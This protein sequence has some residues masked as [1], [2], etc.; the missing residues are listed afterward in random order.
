VPLKLT[1]KP[2]EKI[3]I[4]GAV[5]QNGEETTTLNVL[6]EVPL[7]REKDILTEQQA[8]TICKRIYL[9][10]QLMYM[11]RTNLAMYQQNFSSLL[12]EVLNAAPSTTVYL[13]GICSD[14]AC[15]RY[16]QALK[17]ARALVE[18]E[19]GLIEHAKQST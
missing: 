11:D 2:H 10:V 15:G 16:Y 1:L 4:G 14:L 7:L 13:A 3:F 19:Q 8:D 9:S 6:S 12:N 5:V 18:Y 17:N